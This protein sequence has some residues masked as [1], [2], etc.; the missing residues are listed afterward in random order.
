MTTIHFEFSRDMVSS[1]QEGLAFHRVIAINSIIID[2]VEYENLNFE[3]QIDKFLK[4]E[5]N[6]VEK[7]A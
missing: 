4:E 2:G 1:L 5:K 6:N 3:K 7:S